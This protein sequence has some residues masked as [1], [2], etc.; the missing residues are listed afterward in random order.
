MMPELKAVFATIFLL[1]FIWTFNA[2]D[3]VYLLTAGAADTELVSIEVVNWLFGRLDVGAAAALSI[4]L[5]GHVG[6]TLAVYFRWFY[7]KEQADVN[8]ESSSSSRVSRSVK[9]VSLAFFVFITAF[10]L[11][12]M[13]SL[14]FKDISKILQDPVRL[15]AQLGRISGF[16][17]YRSVLATESDGGFGFVRFIRNS[18]IVALAPSSS[19]CRSE[20]W[21]RMPRPG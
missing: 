12:Y 19:P 4:V 3:E 8:R 6:V 13:I 21:P 11:V 2:F 9:W 15:P 1:R 20:R 17:T 5:A 18:A 14:S 10:P 7:P 16:E